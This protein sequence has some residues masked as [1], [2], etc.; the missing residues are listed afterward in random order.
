MSLNDYKYVDY[1]EQVRDGATLTDVDRSG[2]FLPYTPDTIY[3]AFVRYKS[4]SGLKFKLITES[5]GSYYVDSE[6]SETYEGY[7]FATNA[8]AGYETGNLD[9]TF[10]IDNL[11]DLRYAVEVKKSYGNKYYSPAAPRSY[12]LSA[13][14][15]F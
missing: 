14:Y 6:N 10:N 3:S 13:K 11:T 1:A 5:W 8:M 9:I 12:M 7:A 15:N 2:N 4:E